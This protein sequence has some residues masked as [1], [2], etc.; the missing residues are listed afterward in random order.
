[1][2]KVGDDDNDNEEEQEEG[3]GDGMSVQ[4]PKVT[5]LAGPSAKQK[6]AATFNDMATWFEHN[7]C[8]SLQDRESSTP[9]APETRMYLLHIQSRFN[10]ESRSTSLILL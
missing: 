5:H 10:S 8:R 7:L 2:A 3:Y 6:L 4:S 9:R 1:M